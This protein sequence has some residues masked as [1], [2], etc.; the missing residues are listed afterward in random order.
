LGKY[1]R[2]RRPNLLEDRLGRLLM[3][4]S[5][6]ENLEIKRGGNFCPASS[7]RSY[8]VPIQIEREGQR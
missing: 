3:V 2:I 7:I 1:T 4:S 8:C 5:D 6:K